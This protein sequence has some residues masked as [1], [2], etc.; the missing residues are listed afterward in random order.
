MV[1]ENRITHNLDYGVVWPRKS[2][3]N[4]IQ[5]KGL[6][7]VEKDPKQENQSFYAGFTA[8][9]LTIAGSSTTEL[10]VKSYD[11][12]TE[13]MTSVLGWSSI[14]GF[15]VD[16]NASYDG[17]GFAYAEQYQTPN[18]SGYKVT[19]Y[20]EARA[21]APAEKSTT[22][23]DKV[24]AVEYEFKSTV[25]A[26]STFTL[27]GKVRS[28]VKFELTEE[29]LKAGTTPQAKVFKMMFTDLQKPKTTDFEPASGG[30]G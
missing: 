21:T 1:S 17:F 29:E 8:P 3:G 7:S 22:D 20:P 2:T 25:N 4:G 27:G 15:L 12:P 5:V 9:Y 13:L 23:E 18:S 16:D 11:L 26:D 30:N 14:N 10:T 6:R 24:E 28:A 19:F